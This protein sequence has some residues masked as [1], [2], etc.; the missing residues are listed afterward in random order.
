MFPALRKTDTFSRF[1]WDGP[2]GTIVMGAKKTFI[3]GLPAAR[4]GDPAIPSGFVE[5]GSPKTFI[6]GR[7]AARRIDRI[8]CKI[9]M[10][11]SAKKT[12][13]G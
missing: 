6:E 1:C 9:A 10:I 4:L 8:T 7:P 2:K 11:S 13:I 3:E 12:F 5:T